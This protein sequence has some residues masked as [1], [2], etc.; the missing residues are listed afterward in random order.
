MISSDNYQEKNQDFP[1]L[2]SE[3][4]GSLVSPILTKDCVPTIVTLCW[5]APM[6]F[7]TILAFPFDHLL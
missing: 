5:V 2:K 7:A 3:P 6:Y 1:G 4:L